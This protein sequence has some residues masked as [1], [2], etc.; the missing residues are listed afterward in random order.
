MSGVISQSEVKRL[1]YLVGQ[2]WPKTSE[3]IELLRTQLGVLS[4][5]LNVDLLLDA[6][7]KKALAD[8]RESVHQV[9]VV[10]KLE[11]PFRLA[12]FISSLIEGV[13]TQLQ[14]KHGLTCCSSGFTESNDTTFI[15]AKKSLY[16]LFVEGAIRQTLRVS[17]YEQKIL[18]D[19]N[20]NLLCAVARN[21]SVHANGLG[22]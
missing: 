7:L 20:N 22:I 10:G 2:D 19:G 14:S 1:R 16:A 5:K 21:S 11:D 17:G 12:V 6:A 18:V 13:L 8:Y 9:N 4:S 15:E 3:A